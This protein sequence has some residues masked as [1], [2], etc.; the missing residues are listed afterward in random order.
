MVYA[1]TTC[2]K[3]WYSATYRYLRVCR[4]ACWVGIDRKRK[5]DRPETL[6]DRG[7]VGP[8]GT[9]IYDFRRGSVIAWSATDLSD[10][11]VLGEFG[12]ANDLIE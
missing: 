1:W 8:V 6:A 5:C 2:I 9:K 4:G 11:K 10:K 7:L 12:K 3:T